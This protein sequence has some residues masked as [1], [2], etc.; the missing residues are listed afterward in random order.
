MIFSL[1]TLICA[2]KFAGDGDSF[3]AT[4]GGK[5]KARDVERW[6]ALPIFAAFSF[7]FRRV[8]Y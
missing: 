5:Q 1:N 4:R 8:L 7:A 2:G 6:R 3:T